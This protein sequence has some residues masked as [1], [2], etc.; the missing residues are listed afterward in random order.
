MV[1]FIRVHV[2]GRGVYYSQRRADSVLGLDLASH[3]PGDDRPVEE[4][5]ID[6]FLQ[7]AFPDKIDEGS[8]FYRGGLALYAPPAVFVQEI[9]VV[10]HAV[11]VHAPQ[12]V[13]GYVGREDVV[14]RMEDRQPGRFRVRR[15]NASRHPVMGVENQFALALGADHL[16]DIVYD[17]PLEFGGRVDRVA[18]VCAHVFGEDGRADQVYSGRIYLVP[19]RPPPGL[20]HSGFLLESFFEIQRGDMDV[21]S[22]FDQPAAERGYNFALTPAFSGNVLGEGA[23]LFGKLT[24]FGTDYEHGR[25]P[26]FFQD[27]EAVN[28]FLK[29]VDFAGENV[30]GGGDRSAVRV[31][32]AVDG[33]ILPRPFVQK[34]DVV[35]CGQVPP[36]PQEVAPRLA[37]RGGHF[38]NIPEKLVLGHVSEPA[39]GVPFLVGPGRR[40]K[41]GDIDDGA[42]RLPEAVCHFRRRGHLDIRVRRERLWQLPPEREYPLVFPDMLADVL[43]VVSEEDRFSVDHCYMSGVFLRGDGLFRETVG[44]VVAEVP[45][46]GNDDE[47]RAGGP[48]HGVRRD[49]LSSA[50]EHVGPSFAEH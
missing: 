30:G 28:R 15:N 40:R 22:P 10:R 5:I 3:A 16:D 35:G 7:K 37:G 26:G 34:I 31:E 20:V 4:I 24:R 29:V 2:G 11:H 25:S 33:E 14:H 41:T 8:A 48:E 17:L 44:N 46:P 23:H 12:Q 13:E 27:T 50:Q 21:Y 39:L 6:N 49:M 1:A 9:K 19:Y 36:F 18:R 38:F 43:V 32:I 45:V 47:L 42:H